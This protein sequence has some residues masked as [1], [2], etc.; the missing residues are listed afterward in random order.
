M[1]ALVVL[2]DLQGLLVASGT[3]L[4]VG[5]AL[6]NPFGIY[7]GPALTVVAGSLLGSLVALCVSRL[8]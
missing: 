1:K 8:P 4:A 6:V 7:A 2:C 5:F 3:T